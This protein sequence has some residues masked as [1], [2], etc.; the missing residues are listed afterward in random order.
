MAVLRVRDDKGNII[1]IP[2]IKGDTPVKG[3]DYFTEADK[4]ELITGLEKDRWKVTSFTKVT[5][6]A[7]RNTGGEVNTYSSYCYAESQAYAD[8]ENI[9]Y[10]K[11]I[12]GEVLVLQIEEGATT[13]YLQFNTSPAI[14]NTATI[15]GKA[16]LLNSDGITPDKVVDMAVMFAS[17][18]QG[19]F[20]YFNEEIK[21]GSYRLH[22]NAE[23]IY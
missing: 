14:T 6:N 1:D 9:I 4:A 2:A 19:V 23:S 22:F 18:S 13:A 16:V 10:K 11:E 15:S 20:L 8:D 17:S 3:V 21:A 12:S 7:F 5:N